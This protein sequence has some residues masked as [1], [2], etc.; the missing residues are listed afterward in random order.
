M[1]IKTHRPSL[2]S[3]VIAGPVQRDIDAQAQKGGAPQRI[4]II[5]CLKESDEHGPSGV[6]ESKEKVR[7]FLRDKTD[8]LCES[9]F[10]IFASLFPEDIQSLAELRQWV[11][12]IWKD[13]TTYGHLLHSVDTVKATSCWRTFEARGKGITWAVMDTGINA[14]HPHFAAL[15]TVNVTLSKNFSSSDTLDDRKATGHTWQALLRAWRPR[16]RKANPTTQRSSWK[17]RATRRN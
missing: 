8:Q 17:N 14:A 5:V 10:Y 7:E 16:G 2:K 15:N 4:R 13:E 3:F 12:Q 6:Q 1:G 11:Y 9:D